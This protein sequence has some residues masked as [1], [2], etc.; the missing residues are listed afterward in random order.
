MIS[1][2]SSRRQWHDLRRE[3]PSCAMGVT[4]QASDF[5]EGRRLLRRKRAACNAKELHLAV[6]SVQPQH[7][8]PGWM[9]SLETQSPDQDSAV[10]EKPKAGLLCPCRSRSRK[11]SRKR[12]R[13]LFWFGEST[14]VKALRDGDGTEK[15]D[16][17]SSLKEILEV[18]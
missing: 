1:R 15:G 18:R 10:R 14:S 11:G 8:V 7:D 9:L 16:F 6:L 4:N 17:V 13:S 3:S 12:S 5:V 2:Q